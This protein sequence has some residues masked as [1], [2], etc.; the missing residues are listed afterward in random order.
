MR[1]TA[2]LDTQTS[3][4]VHMYMYGWWL[5]S[6]GGGDVPLNETL[7]VFHTVGWVPWDFPPLP[8]GQLSP[9][10][11]ALLHESALYFVLL[12]TPNGIRSSTIIPYET[13]QLCSGGSRGGA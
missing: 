10:L 12:P 1:K 4:S 11:Q 5:Y 8:V 13:L 6:R 2:D 7:A 9:P 3:T